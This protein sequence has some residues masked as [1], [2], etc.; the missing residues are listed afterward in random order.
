MY[1]IF[2]SSTVYFKITYLDLT[3][4]VSLDKNII[5]LLSFYLEDIDIKI[6]SYL[7]IYLKV[8]CKFLKCKFTN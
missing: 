4:N 8:K 5:I 6:W 3:A 1:N 7:E 2:L